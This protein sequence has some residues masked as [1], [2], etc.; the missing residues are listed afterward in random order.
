MPE[1]SCP[2][3]GQTKSKIAAGKL[4]PMEATKEKPEVNPATVRSVCPGPSTSTNATAMAAGQ[5]SE[6]DQVKQELVP[7]PSLKRPREAEDWLLHP[8]DG[9]V[10][11][12]VITVCVRKNL[13]V[14]GVEVMPH[15][16]AT[17]VHLRDTEKS[18]P[19]T[20]LCVV[21]SAGK[22]PQ[23]RRS[24]ATLVSPSP[25]HT[26]THTHTHTHSDLRHATRHALRARPS[27]QKLPLCL[28][29]GIV[30]WSDRL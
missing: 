28:S 7:A 2:W 11:R 12:Y 27:V 16:A 13:Q 22:R 14:S 26:Q 30:L 17:N 10:S 20:Y 6:G 29:S 23:W 3:G 15:S 25:A 9:S 19:C 21:H 5:G 8:P 1:R 4:E 18:S 24:F